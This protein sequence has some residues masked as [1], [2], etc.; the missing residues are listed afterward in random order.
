MN[1]SVA[2][3]REVLDQV[4]DEAFAADV[5]V[6]VPFPYL[7]EVQQRLSSSQ[8][9]VGAQDVSEYDDGAYTG[10]VSARM[11]KDVGSRLAIVGHSER[12]RYFGESD[13]AVASKLA[14]LLEVGLYGI[15]CVGETLA[16]RDAGRAEA[17]IEAQLAPLHALLARGATAS[18]FCI[19]YEPVWA[20]GTG[21]AA[22]GEQVAVMHEFIKRCLGPAFA[23][24]YG[25]SVKA[26][27]ASALLTLPGVDG[28]LVGGAS[29]D[30][31]EFSGIC[32][33]AGC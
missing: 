17:R 32:R 12:R 9:K 5:S 30:A 18:Q 33:A 19:A 15:Y 21:R 25:G 2:L 22:S 28:V 4:R 1:G 31:K 16:E 7:S 20:I 13:A 11:L 8:I 24:L 3:L 10:E 29:L 26:G 23:V 14:R 6:C 27:N